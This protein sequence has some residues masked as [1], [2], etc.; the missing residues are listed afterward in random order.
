LPNVRRTAFYQQPKTIEH[1]VH[2]SLG[3]VFDC[4]GLEL[5]GMKRWEMQNRSP[6]KIPT[7]V[8]SDSNGRN[9]HRKDEA[10]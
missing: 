1:L 5:P 6:E 10:E 8:Q 4:F 9:S 2:H 7:H 3:R